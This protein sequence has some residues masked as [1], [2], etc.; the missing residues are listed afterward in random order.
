MWKFKWIWVLL[1]CLVGSGIF[2]AIKYQIKGNDLV[3]MFSSFSGALLAFIFSY[4]LYGIKAESEKKLSVHKAKYLVDKISKFNVQV[5]KHIN[6]HIDQSLKDSDKLKWVEIPRYTD[7]SPLPTIDM[8]S[9]MFLVD[10]NEQTLDK[11]LLV[12]LEYQSIL[13]NLEDRNNLCSLYL[14]KIQE[15][16]QKNLRTLSTQG[17]LSPLKLNTEQLISIVGP[18]LFMEVLS[19]T[20]YLIRNVNNL[21][22]DSKAALAEINKL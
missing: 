10:Q 6:K 9:L 13:R 17:S 18:K 14:G 15:F 12:D 11:I 5:L 19:I 20:E 4:I 7:F 22:K 2:I 8:V 3:V 21:E 1:L 16:E